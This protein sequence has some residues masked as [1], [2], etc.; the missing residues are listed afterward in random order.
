[1]VLSGRGFRRRGSKGMSEPQR[2]QFMNTS[3]GVVSRDCCC[4]EVVVGGRVGGVGKVDLGGG[5]RVWRGL[6]WR[7]VMGVKVE[8][9]R[10]GGDVV[11]ANMLG[12]RMVGGLVCWMLFELECLIRLEC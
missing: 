10:N 5:L 11:K 3:S 12:L 8:K 1:M 6:D 4:W 9:R 2:V 7:V